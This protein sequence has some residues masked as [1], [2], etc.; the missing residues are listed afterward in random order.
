MNDSTGIEGIEGECHGHDAIAVAQAVKYLGKR[1]Y[2]DAIAWLEGPATKANK[3]DPR[4]G[5]CMC[6]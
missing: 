1:G 3:K 6:V 4:T 5:V 2:T